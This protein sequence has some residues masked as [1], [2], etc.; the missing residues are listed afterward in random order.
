MHKLALEIHSASEW[1]I[2]ATGGSESVFRMR[3]NSE[4]VLLEWINC[5][6]MRK[7]FEQSLLE[8]GETPRSCFG[9]REILYTVPYRMYT[10]LQKN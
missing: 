10:R 5:V 4:G 2:V 8:G 6:G 7:A 3:G 1:K 9:P